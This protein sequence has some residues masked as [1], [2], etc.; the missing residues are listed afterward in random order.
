MRRFILSCMLVI[1]TAQSGLAA[2][3]GSITGNGGSGLSGNIPPVGGG[4]GS[5]PSGNVNDIQVKAS[6]TTFGALTPGTG[7]S[8]ALSAALN[9]TGALVGSTGAAIAAATL[10]ATGNISQ[11]G[12]PV[13]GTGLSTGFGT[14]AGPGIILSAA[15][16]NSTLTSD[17]RENQF[18]TVLTPSA[19]TNNI[20]E[21]F[22][23]SVEVAGTSPQNGEINVFQSFFTLDAGSTAHDGENYE[24]SFNNGGTISSSWTS[25]LGLVI[26]GSTATIPFYAAYNTNFTNNNTT[27]GSVNVFVNY[28]CT[29]VSGP[30]APPSFDYCIRNADAN[31]IIAT[32][33]KVNIGSIGVPAASLHV[34]GPD[35]VAGTLAMSIQNSA[36]TTLL[37]VADNG[38]TTFG[39]ITGSTQ[40]LQVN[41]SGVLSGTG[42]ACGGGGGAVSSVANS[43][44]TL[45]ISPTTGAV[46]A[47]LALGHANT[48]TAAQTF[49]AATTTAGITDSLS[50][51]SPLVNATG[52]SGL[53]LGGAN[54]ISVASGQQTFVG[55]LSGSA[56]LAGASGGLGNSFFGNSS[57]MSTTTGTENTFVGALTGVYNLTGHQNAYVGMGAGWFDNSAFNAV[58]G[59]DAYRNYVASGDTTNGNNTALGSNTLRLGGGFQNTAIGSNAI[60][61]NSS[62]I[63]IGGTIT[64]TDVIS[65]TFTGSF[66]GSPITV[67]APMTGLT[68]T[69]QAAA[70]VVAAITANP[71][72]INQNGNSGLFA[73]TSGQI[74]GTSSIAM[75]FIGTSVSGSNCVITASVSGAATEVVTI[76]GGATG[77]NNIG[78]G[79]MALLGQFLSTGSSNIA[80]GGTALKLVS[81]GSNNIAIGFGSGAAISTGTINV[82]IGDMA[83][84]T[85]T[86]VQQ[87]VGIG[88]A[89]LQSLSGNGGGT[90]GQTAIGAFAMSNFVSSG[91]GNANTA[92]GDFALQ[93]AAGSTTQAS[94]AVGANAGKVVTTA[95]GVTLVGFNAGNKITTGGGNT[96]IGSGVGSTTLTTGTSDILIGTS[97]AVDAP[98]SST[99]NFVNI[100]N[101]LT[102]N[103]ANTTPSTSATT[104]AG[105]LN[106]VG[107]LSQN[108]TTI[109]QW[110]AGTTG[111]IGGSALLAGA[112]T[113]GTVAVTGSTTAM[114]VVATPVT[115]PGDGF[116]W[117]AFVSAAG[118]V[119]VKVCGFI[120]GTPVASAYNVRVLQ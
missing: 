61:G 15:W 31:G 82:F 117:E 75:A 50:V 62:N 100:Q 24:A 79:Y 25:F 7:V 44:G 68:T 42:A 94:V 70:A 34:E 92:V 49:S 113:S 91:S 71:T 26:N 108:G 63:T 46:V 35:T 86:T 13:I 87:M 38:A 84:D 17:T 74:T 83:G 36:N 45:T 11:G 47:S 69:A 8:T 80:I 81:S 73:S 76:T 110:L 109:L 53:Q 95:A 59:S 33:G 77:N 89:A 37:S 58:I 55:P 118:T 23:S 30:G 103:G 90:N 29:G 85:M 115:Y 21:N 67:T 4:G 48:W 78:I 43:D 107:A 98:T 120:A 14:S 1:A 106:V 116:D 40:C 51:V 19:A 12:E 96:I 101:I 97:S 114:G 32:L 93:G 6:G 64:A 39:T 2:D 3:P 102:I 10:S 20:W 72:L 111:S 52:A 9:G 56:I 27:A 41:T 119:T 54:G 99:S 22:N 5:A 112:C 65:V 18:I 104:I 105:S 16:N 28:A 60:T 66:T 88:H 57:G